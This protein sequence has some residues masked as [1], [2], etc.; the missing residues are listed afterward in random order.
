MNIRIRKAEPDDI[1]TLIT[2]LHQLFAIEKD[3][4]I[5]DDKHR[6]GLQ[7]LLS[8]S[9]ERII[10][11]AQADGVV[12]GMVT[13]QMVVSTAIGGTSVLLEDM[14]V[15]SGFRRQGVGSRLLEQVVIWGQERGAHRVQLVADST[16]TAALRFYRQA[17]LQKSGMVA[18]YGKP[19]VINPE[20]R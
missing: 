13:A 1:E 7:L 20:L 10:F 15:A 6:I 5:D 18:F 14:F 17:G 2:F 8:T 12:V 19:D 9:Q 11:V 16:N 4:I 3:F